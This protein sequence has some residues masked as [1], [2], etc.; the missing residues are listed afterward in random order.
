MSKK[1]KILLAFVC[2]AV[3]YFLLFYRRLDPNIKNIEDILV[4]KLEYVEMNNFVST[5]YVEKDKEK[6]ANILKAL[7]GRTKQGTRS[8]FGR[9]DYFINMGEKQN[10]AIW[11]END[12]V[13]ITIPNVSHQVYKLSRKNAKILLDYVNSVPYSKDISNF[14]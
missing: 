4:E 2:I 9:H 10:Y 12:G 14:F 1:T 11:V 5:I 6:I 8:R 7:K 13:Y 3:I